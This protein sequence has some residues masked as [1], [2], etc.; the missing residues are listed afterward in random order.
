VSDRQFLHGHWYRQKIGQSGHRF[1]NGSIE[2]G[3]IVQR[4]LILFDIDGTLIASNISGRRVMAYALQEAYG[5]VGAL[6]GYSFAGKTDLGIVKHLLTGA[7]LDNEQIRTG[8]PRF[9]ELMSRKGK[10]VFA[11]E[12][13]VPCPGVV[14][15]LA[16]LRTIPKVALGMQ[17]GNIRPTAQQKLR[18]AGLEPSW[19][20]FAGYGSDSSEREGLLPAAWRRAKELTGYAF[21]GH[22]TVVVGDTPGDVLSAQA[23]G[24]PV[25]AVASGTYTLERLAE[26]RPDY[27]L[28]D[29]SDTQVALK[30]LTGAESA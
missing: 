26:Y 9:Y 13:L 16:T 7:G 14:S 15:L 17:T 29:L 8:L 20:P 4:R 3:H 25:I 12:W 18:A 30:I 23:N 11:Q 22:N 21:T 10:E 2:I 1:L 27:L 19:F 5:T 6:D 24:A 28:S